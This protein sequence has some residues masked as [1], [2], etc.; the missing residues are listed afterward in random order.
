MFE[1]PGGRRNLIWSPSE[2]ARFTLLLKQLGFSCPQG[3]AAWR[4]VNAN[5]A[6][7]PRS[8]FGGELLGGLQAT[9]SAERQLERGLRTMDRLS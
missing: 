8:S 6:L 4:V 3:L 5:L 1:T 2:V 7:P 9:I